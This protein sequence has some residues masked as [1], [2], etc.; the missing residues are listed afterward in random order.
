MNPQDPTQRMRNILEALQQ[1][2]KKPYPGEKLKRT[3]IALAELSKMVDEAKTDLLETLA[4]HAVEYGITNAEA[5]EHRTG[6]EQMMIPLSVVAAL[7]QPNQS[8]ETGE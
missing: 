2:S 5:Y 1:P 4:E 6:Q 8:Q 7:Q 3:N